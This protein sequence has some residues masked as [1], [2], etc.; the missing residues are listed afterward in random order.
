MM[1]LDQ[2]NNILQSYDTSI[3]HTKLEVMHVRFVNDGSS[4]EITDKNGNDVS[5]IISVLGV[6][7]LVNPYY[8]SF[9]FERYIHFTEEELAE[10]ARKAEEQAEEEAQA[11]LM[12]AEI[13]RQE[14]HYEKYKDVYELKAKLSE[15]DYCIIKIAEGAADRSEYADIIEQRQQWRD[16]IN[17]LEAILEQEE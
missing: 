17:R 6:Y 16:E 7:P 4:W 11:E 13:E 9:Q 1:I 15:T 5:H 12:Q 2:N 10:K 14:A 3:G 8:Y